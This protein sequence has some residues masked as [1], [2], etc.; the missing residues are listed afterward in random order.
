[1]QMGSNFT[2]ILPGVKPSSEFFSA[3]V[4]DV[5]NFFRILSPSGKKGPRR[6]RLCAH[7]SYEIFPQRDE[8]KKRKLKRFFWRQFAKMWNTFFQ[9]FCFYRDEFVDDLAD[10]AVLADRQNGWRAISVAIALA[11]RQ[12][13]NVELEWFF[14]FRVPSALNKCD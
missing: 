9:I 11:M 1:M 8:L 14:F 2:E 10:L 7:P 13:S 6:Q 5:Q 3:A 12:I 4:F